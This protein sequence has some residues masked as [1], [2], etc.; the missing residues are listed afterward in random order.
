M[1]KNLGLFVVL[2]H[3][4]APSK[5]QPGKWAITETCDFVDRIKNN[6]MESASIILDVANKSFVKCRSAGA[7]FE[8]IDKHLKETYE[9]EYTYFLKLVDFQR[10]AT[11]ALQEE[12][13]SLKQQET[14]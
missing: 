4:Y 11:Q 6:M 5:E 2:T 10:D 9:K 8:E 7:T 1:K 14:K 3:T 13:E 12:I